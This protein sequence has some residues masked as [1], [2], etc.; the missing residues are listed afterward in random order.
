MAAE[1][2]L[3]GVSGGA[4]A[5][6][7]RSNATNQ[8]TAKNMQSVMRT[9]LCAGAAVAVSLLTACGSGSGTTTPANI[10]IVNDTAFT[11]TL[12][13]NGSASSPATATHSS[14]TYAAVTP[15]T[16]TLN[17]A[18]SNGSAGP[19]STVGLGTAQNYTAL[20]YQRGSVV[21]SAVYADNQS[22]PSAGYASLDVANV[23]QDAGPL[24]VYV[25]SPPS[26]DLTGLSPTF[27]S[28][29][30]L[31]TAST[32]AAAPTTYA[33]IVTGSGNPTDVRLTL[34]DQKF[35]SSQPY[36]LALTSTTGGALV[37]AALVPQGINVPASSFIASNQSRVRLLSALPTAAPGT[38]VTASVGTSSSGAVALQ[39]DYAPSPTPYQLVP[40][41]SSIQTLTVVGGGAVTLPA[42]VT[43]SA[44]GDYTILVYGTV[45]APLVS[46]LADSNL[47]IA[48]RASVRMI[49]AA[50]TGNAGVTL[51][52][53]GSLTSSGV[54][55]GTDVSSGTSVSYT[56]VTPAA[57]ATIQP[58]GGG[59]TGGNA[60]AQ[61]LN[62]GSVYTVFVY[63]ATLPPLVITDR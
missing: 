38:E 1:S 27:A 46:V 11:A 42:G 40:A 57:S 12:Y 49:N 59:Y 48:N 13:L 37:D 14:S 33:I 61:G 6:L 52:V 5:L 41:G 21:Y 58:I 36:T 25:V 22:A 2:T 45:A 44:G 26:T 60:P 31:S 39:P 7:P 30:G 18:S 50:V 9:L 62:S 28:V 51:F 53:N 15:S 19:A 56:G 24:D 29:Q 35:V 20:A 63:D 55:Y 10:R 43:F 23:S 3:H 4:P 17:V 47:I 8:E 54:L 32:F 34:L 16:Y